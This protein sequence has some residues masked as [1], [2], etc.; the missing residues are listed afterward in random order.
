M[1][2]PTVNLT[3]HPCDVTMSIVGSSPSNDFSNLVTYKNEKTPKVTSVDPPLGT[4]IG[5]TT[6]TITGEKF[7]SDSKVVIDDIDCP[8]SSV[9]AT[10]IVCVTGKRPEFTESTLEVHSPSVG[11]AITGETVFLYIDR[12]SDPNTWG[13]EAAPREGDSVHVPKGQVLLVDVSPPELYAVIVEGVIIWEDVQDLTFRCLV[14]HG[15]RRK[16]QNRHQ[17]KAPPEQFDHHTAWDLGVEDPA[18]IRK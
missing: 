13:G 1:P 10:E 14:H 8:V 5:G 2:I 12:W 3:T 7:E 11:R 18:W 16:A 17:G 4:T 9:S 15:S 6:I